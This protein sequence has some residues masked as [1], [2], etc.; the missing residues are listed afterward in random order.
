MQKFY[1]KGTRLLFSTN[2]ST[3]C[4]F[5]STLEIEEILNVAIFVLF[6]FM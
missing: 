6:S 1:V 3:V 4:K 5:Y 2:Y